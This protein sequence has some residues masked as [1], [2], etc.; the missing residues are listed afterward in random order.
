VGTDIAAGRYF[1]NPATSCYWER[2]RGF[3]GS[4]NDVI[5][6]EFIGFDAG[7]WVVD[8]LGSDMA[9][10]TDA[11]CGTWSRTPRPP[12][13]GGITPGVWLVGSQVAPGTYRVNARSGCY[14]ERLR[15]FEGTLSSVID[16]KFVADAS[17]QLV[18]IASSD[19][20]FHNDGDCGTWA[21][22]DAGAQPYRA[23]ASGLSIAEAFARHKA[24]RQR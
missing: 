22:G 3:S 17:Q 1:T 5:A 6:N 16:N 2:Q 4:L 13:T 24:R 7:Q 14:W 8:I 12:P 21:V 19:V 15:A 18:T 11:E 10:E 20:G 9:F 23:G